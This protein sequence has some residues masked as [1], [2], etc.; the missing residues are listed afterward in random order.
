MLGV[1]PQQKIM[2]LLHIEGYTSKEVAGMMRMSVSAVK[3]ASHRAIKKMKEQL[4][5]S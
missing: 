1:S 5:Q 2:T 4:Q 3:V